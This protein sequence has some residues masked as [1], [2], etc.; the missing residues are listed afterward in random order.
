MKQDKHEDKLMGEK[1]LFS[2]LELRHSRS[3]S[4]VWASLEKV[5]SVPAHDKAETTK[6]IFV[7]WKPLSVAASV[8]ILVGLGLFAR[9]FTTTVTVSRGEFATY[10]L[11]DESKVHLNAESTITYAPYW[12][13]I[14][15]TLEMEGEAFFEVAKGKKFSVASQMGITEVLGTKFNINTREGNYQVYCTEGKV[16]VRNELSNQVLLPGD[17]VEVDKLGKLQSEDKNEKLILAWRSN[18]FIYN[19]TPLSKVFSDLERHYNTRILLDIEEE[20]HFT[21]IFQRSSTVEEAL[22]IICDS[23]E[24]TFENDVDTTYIIK[25]YIVL[26]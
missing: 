3:K 26:N 22:E 16:N 20:Y 14:N 12:W 5:S 9:F 13:S 11:P 17:F 25:E 19:T 10:T 15:R 24:L 23:F 18:K 8:M 6:T 7:N 4:E 1:D 21:G 2:K